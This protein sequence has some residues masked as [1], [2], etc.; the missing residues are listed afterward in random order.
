VI[1]HGW[2]VT[3]V[4]QAFF[5]RS[6][7]AEDWSGGHS[8]VN[9]GWSIQRVE[10]HNV[11]SRVALLHRH[12]CVFLL[13]GNDTCSTTGAQAAGEHLQ[14]TTSSD[15]LLTRC[16]GNKSRSE[17]CALN[18]LNTDYKRRIRELKK[19]QKALDFPYSEILF[20]VPVRVWPEQN[21]E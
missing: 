16:R 6:V 9:V 7:D 14:S 21:S 3:K 18:A 8:S 13:G 17:W 10:H 12:R 4:G 2:V 5:V 11:V 19:A 1:T 20:R 15:W